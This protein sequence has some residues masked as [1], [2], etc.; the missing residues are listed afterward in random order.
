MKQHLIHN[1]LSRQ[2]S[3]S[4]GLKS[5][6]EKDVERAEGNGKLEELEDIKQ[7][8]I[9]QVREMWRESIGWMSDTQDGEERKI[10][11]G[12]SAIGEFC[13]HSL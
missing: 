5:S 9:D 4:V 10:Q 8:Q 12:A 6:S 1:K 3:K 2:P 11:Q 7:R 13:F